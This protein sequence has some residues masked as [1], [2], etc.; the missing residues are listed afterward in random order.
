MP[1]DLKIKVAR[2]CC[3]GVAFLHSKGLMHCDIKSLNFLVTRDFTVKLADLGEARPSR[4]V[5]S[6]D[7]GVLP[8]YEIYVLCNSFR[9]INWSPPEVLSNK[10]DSICELSDVWSLSMVVAEILTGEIPF[11]SQQMR[12]MTVENFVDALSKNIRPT[13]PTSA[14]P[15][16]VKLVS[17]GW[18]FESSTRCSAAH[19][20]SVLE[21]HMKRIED[22]EKEYFM[23]TGS[24]DI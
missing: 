6:S 8:K 13:L 3:A 15:W 11:D 2:D 12:A 5:R 18:T 9:N 7:V 23:R 1:M 20:Q 21:S 14:E 17:S 22:D 10:F 19:M 4:N 16:L 24:I